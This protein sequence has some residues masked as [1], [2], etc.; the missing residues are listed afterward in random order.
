MKSW[1]SGNSYLRQ[2]SSTQSCGTKL[3]VHTQSQQELQSVLEA[4][5]MY[6]MRTNYGKAKIVIHHGMINIYIGNSKEMLS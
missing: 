2:L 1:S 5:Q 6:A 3:T 4:I